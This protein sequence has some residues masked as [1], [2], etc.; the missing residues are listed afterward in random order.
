VAAG[1]VLSVCA[2]AFAG[3]PD[4][5]QPPIG[6]SSAVTNDSVA[7]IGAA[8]NRGEPVLQHESKRGY[9]KSLLRELKIS[10]S[11][12]TLVFSKT[13]FQ[14]D[15]ISPRHPRA[16]YFNDDTY[17]GYVPGG[18][19]IEIA[20]T[21]AKLG[22]TFYT[23]D[24]TPSPKVVRQTENCLQCHGESMT[25]GVP[26]LLM[27]SVFSDA[28]GLP[29]LSAGTYTTSHESPWS[30][31]W[32]GWYVTGN[33][34]GQKH[35]GNTISREQESAEPQP[36]EPA[37]NDR[38][39]L[40]PDV[41]AAAY[42]TP[43]SDVVALMVLEHQVEAHNRIT[44]AAHGT[45]RA[46]RDE[47]IMSDA[48]GEATKPGVHS[49]STLGRIKSSCEPLVE[50]LLFAGEPALAAPVT[51]SS[52]FA[53]EF[54]QRGPRD[55]HGRSLRDFDLKSRLF[56][57]PCSYLIY[58]SS[59]DGLPDEAK[60]YLHRRLWEVLSGKDADNKAFAH[61]SSAD[62]A[63]IAEILR[64]TKPQVRATWDALEKAKG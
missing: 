11:S 7:P 24:Q 6:Y 52:T 21:D 29:I 34:G 48:L 49:D 30:E 35:M 60:D 54:S 26:G 4:Y 56:R 22:T 51:G 57:Y 27:R 23:I 28:N 33:T 42:L 15:H 50:Y 8:V 10:P 19:V 58:S 3:V 1:I 37:A 2:I 18:D 46:L 13:S 12:Q 32:G 61:L 9:L 38:D 25:R 45:L 14:R 5:E 64:E 47:K 16:I 62:R 63:A 17:V 20:S 36:I 55:A 41:N 39:T 44:R 43:H 40:P 31:R 59:I 53:S